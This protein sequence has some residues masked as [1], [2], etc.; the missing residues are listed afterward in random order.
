MTYNLAKAGTTST[1][2]VVSLEII[3]FIFFQYFMNG[4]TIGKRLLR[5]QIVPDKGEKLKK[6]LTCEFKRVTYKEC[7]DILKKS[8]KDFEFKPSTTID[9]GL[10]KFAKWFWEYYGH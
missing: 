5:I 8:G 7:I 10:G 9:E 6:V 2:L 4:Q 3:Y 1:V